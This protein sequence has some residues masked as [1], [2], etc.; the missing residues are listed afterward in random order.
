ME[1]NVVWWTWIIVGCLFLLVE[2]MT[3]TFF[4]LW[5][6][7]AAL[8]PALIALIWP[9]ITLMWQLIIW[10]I[11]MLLCSWLWM[12]FN[13]KLHASKVLEDTILGQIGVLA[14]PCSD[15][16]QGLLLLQKPVQGASEWRCISDEPL[17][18]ETRVIVTA[19]PER[20]LVLVKRTQSLHQQRGN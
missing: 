11:S 6:S 5:M 16:A 9:E 3:T 14:R 20:H 2:L 4:C 10:V 15:T 19:Q 12:R 18:T 17:S 8:A 7:I 13:H 1:L